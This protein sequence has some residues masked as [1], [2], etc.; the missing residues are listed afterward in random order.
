VY[1]FAHL[2][3]FTYSVG[4]PWLMALAVAFVIGLPAQ[5]IVSFVVLVRSLQGAG[6]RSKRLQSI[7]KL[8]LLLAVVTA[9]AIGVFVWLD[10]NARR[11]GRAD[12]MVLALWTFSTAA[13]LVAYRRSSSRPRFN[14]GSG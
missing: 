9:T 12:A 13:A 11:L 10:R 5:A 14:E 7:A 2:A 6:A 3:T 4:P 8:A 1:A